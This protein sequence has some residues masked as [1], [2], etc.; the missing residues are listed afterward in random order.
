MGNLI[1]SNDIV[2]ITDAMLTPRSELSGSADENMLVLTDLGRAFRA[3]DLTTDDYLFDVDFSSFAETIAAIVLC[4][5]NFDAVQI[6]GD[7]TSLDDSA[8]DYTG[9]ELE[10]SQ[11]DITGL[12]NIFIPLTGFDHSLL[13]VFIPSGTSAVGSYTTTW[14][15]GSFCCLRTATA[16]T[17]GHVEY[18]VEPLPT[19]ETVKFASGGSREIIT[20]SHEIWSA[21]VRFGARNSSEEAEL[22]A[23]NRMAAPIVF[24]ENDGDTSKVHICRRDG[25]Y[26]SSLIAPGVVRGDSIRYVEYG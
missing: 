19:E 3:N 2:S 14:Q 5:V 23:L 4:N 10:I 25:K 17:K 13:R 9:D 1:I 7:D 26:S 20:N 18:D 8:L 11:D 21:I 6:L 22:W 16:L 24:Y 12:Y 15:V